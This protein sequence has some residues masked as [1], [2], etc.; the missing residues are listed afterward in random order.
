MLKSNDIH[1][2]CDSEEEANRLQEIEWSTAYEGLV[3]RQLKFGLVIH[4]IPIEE[5]NPHI[6]N[7]DDIAA[8]I[9]ALNNLKDVK[10]RTL[11]APSKLDPIARNNSFIVLTH[12]MEAADECLKKGIFLNC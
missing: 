9:G 5:I 10:L 1:F 4:G 6:D 8:E 7:L 12:D 2:E 3:V 11:R